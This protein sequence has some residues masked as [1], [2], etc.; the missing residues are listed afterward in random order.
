MPIVFELAKAVAAAAEQ[1]QRFVDRIDASG[2]G[3]RQAMEG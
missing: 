2:N 1:V 3:E